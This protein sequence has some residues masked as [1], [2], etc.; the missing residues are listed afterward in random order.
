GLPMWHKAL[1]L[2]GAKQLGQMAYL[3]QSVDFWRLRPEPDLLPID[4]AASSPVY[5]AATPAKDLSMV[6][7]L[8]DRL[9]ELSLTAM[10]RSPNVTWFNPRKGGNSPAVAVVVQ[11]KCQFPTPDA[12]DWVLV[13]KGGK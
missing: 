1:F 8:T 11:G 9:V 13:L 4:S 5:A 12:G 6:Y 2:P 7:V 10:P 3:F